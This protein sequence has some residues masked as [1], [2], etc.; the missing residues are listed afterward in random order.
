MKPKTKITELDYIKAN[1]K[2]RREINISNGNVCLN[3]VHSSKKAYKRNNK[4][5]K[6]GI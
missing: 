5:K 2:A 1:R 4:H 6:L 3:K